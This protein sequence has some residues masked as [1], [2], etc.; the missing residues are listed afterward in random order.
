MNKSILKMLAISAATAALIQSTAQA[1][2]LT[3]TADIQFSGSSTLHDFE[4]RA[5]SK[6]FVASFTEDQKNGQLQVAA[7]AS[8]SVKDM[9]TEN[10]KRDKKMF[11]M[12]DLEHFKFITGE[13]TETALSLKGSTPATLRL[14]IRTVEHEVDA[15]ISDVRRDGNDIS[16]IMKFPISL[17][18]FDLKGPS[19]LGLIRVDDTVY[20]ECT[21]KGQIAETVAGN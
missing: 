14:K 13:L 16:C 18:A 19:V 12:F 11:K 8:L 2:N 4:G 1:G 6:P 17:K 9:D 20:V 10:S 5:S 7:K 3:A 15:T 21:I